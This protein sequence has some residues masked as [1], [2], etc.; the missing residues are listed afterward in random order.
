METPDLPRRSAID[1]KRRLPPALETRCVSWA[2]VCLCQDAVLDHDHAACFT[3]LVNHI[4]QELISPAA[5]GSI[6]LHISAYWCNEPGTLHCR[7][8]KQPRR[9]SMDTGLP[10]RPTHKYDSNGKR[11]VKPPRLS[12]PGTRFDGTQVWLQP[13]HYIYVIIIDWAQSSFARHW[14]I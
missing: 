10:R 13:T 2:A 7:D 6:A 5:I 1:R 9:D 14:M 11:V 8:S 4:A 12:V 3:S